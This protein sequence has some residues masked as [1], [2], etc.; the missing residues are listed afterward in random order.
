MN[1]LKDH[2]SIPESVNNPGYDIAIREQRSNGS[3]FVIALQLKWSHHDAKSLLSKSQLKSAWESTKKALTG[4]GKRKFYFVVC[5]WRDTT[6]ELATLH[7]E[8][9]EWFN[10]KQEEREKKLTNWEK[11]KREMEPEMVVLNRKQLKKLYS[12][13]LACRPQFLK[14]LKNEE[15]DQL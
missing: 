4:I 10:L 12:P 8:D 1:G 2:V 11:L 13:T 14:K 15:S 5:S 3:S 6:N 7:T 9:P